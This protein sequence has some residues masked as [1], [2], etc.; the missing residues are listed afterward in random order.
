MAKNIEIQIP[1][2]GYRRLMIFN[3][4]Y[5]E[6][7]ESFVLM[8]FGFIGKSGALLDSYCC[9]ISIL[10][11]EAQKKSL[12]DYLGQAGSLGDPP[13]EWQPTASETQIDVCNHVG[14]CGNPDLAEITLNN[15]VGRAVAELPSSRKIT[16]DP[17]AL[18]RS[19]LNLQK[20]WIKALYQ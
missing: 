17:V 16:P 12:M 9:G 1:Q 20:H 10:E 3:R 11:L 14:L 5:V 15:F 7:V 19:T 18:L 2:G 6:R 13:P 8:H 4:I